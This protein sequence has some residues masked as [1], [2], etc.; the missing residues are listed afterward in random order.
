[1]FL[2]GWL[3]RKCPSNRRQ[4]IQTIKPFTVITMAWSDILIYIYIFD[5]ICIFITTGRHR[6]KT[7]SILVQLLIPSLVEKYWLQPSTLSP[8]QMKPYFMMRGGFYILGI[9]PKGKWVD[10]IPPLT[11]PTV[12]QSRLFTKET[13]CSMSERKCSCSMTHPLESPRHS[14]TPSD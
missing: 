9:W 8:K 7:G 2:T 10:H 12:F 11:P 5:Y 14:N 3:L 4:K 13:W 6:I 1:M